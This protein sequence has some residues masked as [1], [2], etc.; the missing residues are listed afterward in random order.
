MPGI[1]HRAIAATV[2]IA[3]GWFGWV[4]ASH[5]LGQRSLIGPAM[6]ARQ[7]Q[8]RDYSLAAFQWIG[9]NTPENAV[10]FAVNDPVLYLYTGRHALRCR[11]LNLTFERGENGVLRPTARLIEFA[12]AQLVTHVFISA[13]DFEIPGAGTLKLN[14]DGSGLELVFRDDYSAVCRVIGR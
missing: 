11:D 7:R 8:M 12:R 14:L 6:L 9:R 4:F 10:F 2:L 5:V 13:N 1:L 3:L